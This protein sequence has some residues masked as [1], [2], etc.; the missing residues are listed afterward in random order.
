MVSELPLLKLPTLRSLLLFQTLP[1]PV[2]SAALLLPEVA[3]PMLPTTFFTVP[4]LVMVRL[5]PAPWLPTL[6]VPL[7]DQ[8]EPE[9]VTITA[10]LLALAEKP[11][12]PVALDTVP[13]SAM[14]SRLLEPAAPMVRLAPKVSQAEPV[15]V[16]VTVLL[17]APIFWPIWPLALDTTPP[18]ETVRLF[19]EP[20]TP[21]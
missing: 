19:P 3:L 8:T 11:M 9:P 14:I 10:L 18:L 17:L 7:L 16:T 15:P 2:T 20:Q 5:L 1:A 6:R 12:W 13:P 4:P 21:T